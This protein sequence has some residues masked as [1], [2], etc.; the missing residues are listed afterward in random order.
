MLQ[1]S[2]AQQHNAISVC[3]SGVHVLREN[4]NV[5][6]DGVALQKAFVCKY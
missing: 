6:C 3:L 1:L 5:L 4:N 2:S